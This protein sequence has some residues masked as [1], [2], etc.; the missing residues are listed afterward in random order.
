MTEVLEK[1]IEDDAGGE[2]LPE[3]RDEVAS[4]VRA[5]V[6]SDA[7][8]IDGE[9]IDREWLIASEHIRRGVL[10]SSETRSA[11]IPFTRY[12]LS[13]DLP[14]RALHAVPAL[15]ATLKK[16]S[17]LDR[18]LALPSVPDEAIIPDIHYAPD[19]PDREF[20]AR[21]LSHIKREGGES[22]YDTHLEDLAERGGVGLTDTERYLVYLR[23]RQARDVKLL[24]FMA[25]LSEEPG[26]LEVIEGDLVGRTLKSGV[27]M[28]MTA[29]AASADPSILN[30]THWQGRKAIK[31]RVY[32][33]TINDQEYILKERKTA[34]HYDTAWRGHV[35]GLTS[36]EEFNA[37]RHF[38]SLGTI[39]KDDAD[40]HWE[41]PVGYVAFPD[42]FQ[43]CLF[44]SEAGME[45]AAWI[46]QGHIVEDLAD[47]I[48]E[49]GHLYE[50]EF[51]QAKKLAKQIYNEDD[52]FAMG[53]AKVQDSASGTRALHWSRLKARITGAERP[54][55][56]NRFNLP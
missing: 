34:K 41:K 1:P 29:E 12:P 26:S 5:P 20:Q 10:S 30:P 23:Y 50:D 28:V 17:V 37:A 53:R 45:K 9:R 16:L 46:D 4:V 15:S 54:S 11:L 47:A 27:E 39:Q 35:D 48:I 49:N 6:V 3:V 25:E 21:R 43:F 8:L 32:A 38:A 33:V 2:I 52:S 31:D 22:S 56:K 36:K 19:L 42:G 24:A 7:T 40:F 44:E 55:K 14:G 51:A 13:E 18:V